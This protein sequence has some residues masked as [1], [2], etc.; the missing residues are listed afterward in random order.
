MPKAFGIL[1]PVI[2]ASKIPTCKPDLDKYEASAEVT[3]DLPTPPL[4]LKTPITLLI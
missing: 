1:G 3:K 4:P 2:S